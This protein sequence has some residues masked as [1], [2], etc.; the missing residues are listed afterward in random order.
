M[1]LGGQG[2]LG[3]VRRPTQMAGS[4]REVLPEGQEWYGGPPGGPGVIGRPSR[5]AES[6][7][8][9]HQNC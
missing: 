5:M 9:A 7:R 8:K 3:V 1:W 6:G 4:G 2:G